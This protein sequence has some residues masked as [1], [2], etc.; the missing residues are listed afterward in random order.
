VAS[1]YTA[2]YARSRE[3]LLQLGTHAIICEIAD[4]SDSQLK[5]RLRQKEVLAHMMSTGTFSIDFI[6]R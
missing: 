3:S 6:S 2:S 4:V 5:S 1:R